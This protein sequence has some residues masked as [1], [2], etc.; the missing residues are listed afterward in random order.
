MY[1]LNLIRF[2]LI[3]VY[4]NFINYNLDYIKLYRLEIRDS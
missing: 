1:K 2:R 4:K 3:R